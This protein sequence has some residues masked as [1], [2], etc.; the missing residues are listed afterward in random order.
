M[1]HGHGDDLYI[2]EGRIKYNFSSNIMSGVDQRALLLDLSEHL[3]DISNYPDPSASKLEQLLAL[4]KSVAS[5]NVIVTNG[6]TEAIYLIAQ[7][8]TGR[9]SRILRPTFREY[10]D[11]CRIFSHRIEFFD[12]FET[13]Q[14][15]ANLV[16]LCNPNNPTGTM[17]DPDAILEKGRR[18]P[19]VVFVV[20]QAYSEYCIEAGITSEQAVGAGNIILLGSM[21]KRFSVPGLRLGYVIGSRQLVAEMKRRKMPWSVNALAISAGL[22]L[23]RHIEDYPIDASWFN[24]EIDRICDSLAAF[25]IDSKPSKCNFA[26]FRL[27]K[28]N[29][30]E[31][32]EYLV[33]N[34]GIL[35]RDASNFEGLDKRFFR[36]AAQNREA[37]DLLIKAIKNYL[38]TY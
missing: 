23:M 35:I 22:Y 20:D 9:I 11:A 6:A 10:Q 26:L 34:N 25:G 12:D 28:G 5:E 17:I 18:Y 8:F 21:T 36:V 37:N 19:E 4:D 24:L 30:S 1:V 38:E 2:Y 33:E 31:L 15:K 29:A 27:P 3:E 16:W 13:L 32:K 14:P 7:I